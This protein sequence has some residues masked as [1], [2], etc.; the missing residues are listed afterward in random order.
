MHANQ[1]YIYSLISPFLCRLPG[2]LACIHWTG[3]L[4]GLL[5]RAACARRNGICHSLLQ[6]QLLV[7]MTYYQAARSDALR[8]RRGYEDKGMGGQKGGNGAL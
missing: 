1:F 7:K 3:T 5:R 4:E 2:A 8:G 6:Q